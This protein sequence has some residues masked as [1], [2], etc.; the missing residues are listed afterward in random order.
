VNDFPLNT[1][2]TTAALNRKDLTEAAIDDATKATNYLHTKTNAN[3]SYHRHLIDMHHR[4]FATVL[5]DAHGS[6]LMVVPSTS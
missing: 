5:F 1:P 2:H 6:I 3:P 4:I